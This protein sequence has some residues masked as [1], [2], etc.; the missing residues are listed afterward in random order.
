MRAR[1]SVAKLLMGALAQGDRGSS[2]VR[3][4]SWNL[5]NG[6][7]GLRDWRPQ[8][9]SWVFQFG[10][11][12]RRSMDPASVLN[13]V[14]GSPP[15]LGASVG[16]ALLPSNMMDRLLQ[17]GR[18]IEDCALMRSHGSSARAR[19]RR[20]CALRLEPGRAAREAEDS[21]TSSKS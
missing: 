4:T 9:A 1:C 2:A 5:E 15:H 17:C 21:D 3:P 8:P 11:E 20:R 12:T 19:H 7:S 18:L 6:S 14:T 13:G 16:T 10:T